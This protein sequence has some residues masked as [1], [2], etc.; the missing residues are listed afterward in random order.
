MVFPKEESNS[1]RNSVDFWTKAGCWT[2]YEAAWRAGK[3]DFSLLYPQ[4]HSPPM[5]HVKNNNYHENLHGCLRALHEGD[6][7]GFHGK[8]KDAKKELVLSISRASEE[9]TEFIYSAVVKLQENV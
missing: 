6:C 4:T 5:Q 8:L 1:K 9:S 7:N 2:G 3:W